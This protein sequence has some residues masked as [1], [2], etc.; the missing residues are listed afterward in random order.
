MWLRD[1]TNSGVACIGCP[2]LPHCAANMCSGKSMKHRASQAKLMLGKRNCCVIGSLQSMWQ[3]RIGKSLC[4]A[5]AWT[6]VF[7]GYCL[8][9][10]RAYEQPKHS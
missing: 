2:S 8:E 3:M 9:G 7:G 1:V 6:L 5:S 10:A 4:R